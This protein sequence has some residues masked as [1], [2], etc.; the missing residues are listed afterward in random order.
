[1]SQRLGA[2]LLEPHVPLLAFSKPSRKAVLDKSVSK[3]RGRG[4]LDCPESRC[5]VASGWEGEQE[6]DGVKGHRDDLIT[7]FFSVVE[8]ALHF[9]LPAC[10]QLIGN[11]PNTSLETKSKSGK[12][13]TT[14]GNKV[15]K[16]TALGRSG[17]G[18]KQRETNEQGGGGGKK[19]RGNLEGDEFGQEE[20]RRGEMGVK[21]ERGGE[22]GRVGWGVGG[23]KRGK[24]GW[25]QTLMISDGKRKKEEMKGG[26]RVITSQP[27]AVMGRGRRRKGRKERGAEFGGVN[28]RSG[29]GGQSNGKPGRPSLWLPIFQLHYAASSSSSSS[30]TR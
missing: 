28:L 27:R 24:D 4:S 6:V 29:G 30:S 3:G 1:M 5:R 13:V 26:R 9:L 10:W 2:L 15:V 14:K 18:D 17:G 11:A 12:T 19:W 21:K 20:M 22:Q 7:T 25:K 16:R 23:V 8:V